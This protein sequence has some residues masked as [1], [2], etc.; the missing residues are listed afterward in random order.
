MMY[1]TTTR[2]CREYGGSPIDPQDRHAAAVFSRSPK[3]SSDELSLPS[4]GLNP[5]GRCLR[6]LAKTL[7]NSLHVKY[8]EEELNST[9]NPVAKYFWNRLIGRVFAC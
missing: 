6:M 7:A 5:P 1:R 4:P 3:I 9:K 8:F 2:S